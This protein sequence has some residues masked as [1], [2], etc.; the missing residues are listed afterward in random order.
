MDWGARR[1]LKGR[2]SLAAGGR[3]DKRAGRSA[4]LST[5]AV[6]KSVDAA[7]PGPAF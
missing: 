1:G 5:E 2:A 3:G 4:S 6:D 7:A